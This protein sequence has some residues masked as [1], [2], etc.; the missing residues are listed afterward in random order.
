MSFYTG[1]AALQPG[2]SRRVGPLI[3][4]F[5]RGFQRFPFD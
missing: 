5:P 4:S 3:S 1:S 2:F